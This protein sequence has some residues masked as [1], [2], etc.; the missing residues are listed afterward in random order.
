MHFLIYVLLNTIIQ[1]VNAIFFIIADQVFNS[2]SIILQILSYIIAIST[3]AVLL[4]CM[5]ILV[6]I[7]CAHCYKIIIILIKGAIVVISSPIILIFS[8][9]YNLSLIILENEDWRR[10]RDF[11]ML[12]GS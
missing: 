1:P 2:D 5:S 11:W 6:D 8:I 10:Q 3:L 4:A 7:I 12:I 9:H